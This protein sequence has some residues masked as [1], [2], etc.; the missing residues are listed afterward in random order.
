M[1]RVKDTRFF[2][3]SLPCSEIITLAAGWTFIF[4][5]SACTQALYD[6]MMQSSFLNEWN[7]IT[8]VDHVLY[9]AYRTKRKCTSEKKDSGMLQGSLRVVPTKNS[10]KR[11]IYK[12]Q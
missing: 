3:K 8:I 12:A 6:K 2:N 11:S 5:K 7:F 1:L 4:T 10:L 9:T